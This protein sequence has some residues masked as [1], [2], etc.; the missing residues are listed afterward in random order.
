MDDQLPANSHPFGFPEEWYY[1]AEHGKDS[2]TIS[3]QAFPAPDPTKLPDRI[4]RDHAFF[5]RLILS[6]RD[7]AHSSSAATF[8][9]QDVDFEEKYGRADLRR[10]MC[11][12]T[13][14]IV[15]YARP[16]SQSYSELPAL[17]YGKMGIKLPAFTKRLHED[18]L[19]KRNQIFAHADPAAIPH[20]KLGIMKFRNTNDQPFSILTPPRFQEGTLLDKDEYEQVSLLISCLSSAIYAVA[21]AMHPYVSDKYPEWETVGEDSD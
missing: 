15:S 6:L 18:L 2:A 10:F 21:N 12:E 4:L 11:Y 5:R 13:T 7:I 14:L 9:H 8:I 16:F 3:Y 1:R 19:H 17:T 20:S